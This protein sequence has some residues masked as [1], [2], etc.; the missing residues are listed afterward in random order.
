MPASRPRRC[1]ARADA[2]GARCRI[3]ARARA[4]SGATERLRAEPPGG[5]FRRRQATGNVVLLVRDISNPFYLDVYGG[6]EE[7]AF[8]NGYRV[9]MGDAGDD[10]ARVG[11]YVDMVR[12]RQADG[13]ILMTRLAAGRGCGRAAAANGGSAR[14]AAS[15]SIF[16]PS[17]STTGRRPAGRRPSDRRSATGRS[18]ISPARWRP[19]D[20]AR[21][22]GRASASALSGGGHRDER[23]ARSC[24]A[25]STTAAGMRRACANWLTRGV[26]FTGA[27]SPPM[28]RWRSVPSTSSARQGLRVPEDVSVVGFDDLV[29][30][31]ILRPAAHHDPSAA[32]RHRQPS[33]CG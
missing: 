30:R 15:S 10:D 27:C 17:P 33:R 19:C 2:A 18:P 21:A 11:R 13:L 16:P 3:D 22:R 31:R 26:A 24:R 28:T 9:L 25:I 20:V 5:G 23:R 12:N 29:L 4:G 6:V 32:P 7:H 14:A 1:R 8:A